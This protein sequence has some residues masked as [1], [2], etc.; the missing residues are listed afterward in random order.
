M[1]LAHAVPVCAGMV[2]AALVPAAVVRS[3][4][5]AAEIRRLEWLKG[6]WE[7]RNERRSIEERWM[8]PRAHSM[9]NVGRTVR[10]DSLFEY[11]LV[12]LREHRDRFAYEAHP[13]GQPA[14]TFLS[15]SASDS[16]VVFENPE[17]DFPQRVGYRRVGTDSLLA[18]I[19][20]KADGRERR[21][22]FR[23]VRVNC[24]P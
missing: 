2:L 16:S 17:H 7:T 1:K 5:G 15:I 19:E 22:E 18:W 6:C 13:S 4:T 3:A 10:G 8:P 9:L 14:A 20:G 21:I 23:Y 12:V 11:E 24:E